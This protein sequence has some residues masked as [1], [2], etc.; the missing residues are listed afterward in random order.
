MH[1]IAPALLCSCLVLAACGRAGNPAPAGGAA[2]PPASDA[3]PAASATPVAATPRGDTTTLT[4]DRI[5]RYLAAQRAVSKLVMAGEA[6]GD[7]VG[8]NDSESPEAYAGR[9]QRYPA[10]IRAI[11]DAGLSPAEFSRIGTTLVAGLMTVAAM[12]AGSLKEVPEG[13]DPGA[14][15]FVRAHQAEIEAKMRELEQDTGGE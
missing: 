2:A 5:D 7:A 15:D 12:D 9:M 6:D 1:R 10:V 13:I 4:M 14:V 11:G 8:V 3:A